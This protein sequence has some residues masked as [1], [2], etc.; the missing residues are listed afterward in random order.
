LKKIIKYFL[1]LYFVKKYYRKF[2]IFITTIKFKKK[3][4]IKYYNG[5]KLILNLKEYTAWSYYFKDYEKN[6]SNFIKKILKKNSNAIDI[7]ANL[8]YY[9]IL[10][11]SIL[12]NGQVY[13]FEPEKRNFKKLMNNIKLNNC[14]NITAYNIGLSNS[15]S[16]KKLFLT[17]EINE[18]GHHILCSS[19]SEKT[20]QTIYTNKLDNLIK[21]KKFFEIVKIDVE[22]YE[23]EVLKGMKNVLKKT[24]YVIIENNNNFE[25]INLILKKF[26]FKK[27]KAFKKDLIFKNKNFQL[28]N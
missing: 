10:F 17:T 23:L 7:G 8:G 3:E 2:I 16:Q 12:K 9:S 18:G 25:K 1:S 21:N 27:I 4:I 19:S 24:H 11:S 28:L 5:Y 15:K 14:K 13:A 22:G 20:Y 6:V 26:N